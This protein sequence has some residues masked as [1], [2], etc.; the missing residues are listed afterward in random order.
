MSETQ[1]NEQDHLAWSRFML[2]NIAVIAVEG[3]SNQTSFVDRARTRLSRAWAGLGAQ[4]VEGAMLSMILTLEAMGC[5]IK[6][7]QTSPENS[8]V[9]VEPFPG[10]AML[11]G[12]SDRFEIGMDAAD[13]QELLAT[14]QE[15]ADR[16]YDILG[17]IADGADVEYVRERTEEGD[18]R[19]VLRAW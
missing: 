6:S 2:A 4:G 11:E 10:G 5:R 14:D 18:V 3:A 1:F 9:I 12:L 19:L 15:A 13:W 16:I 7:T 8:E 17:A